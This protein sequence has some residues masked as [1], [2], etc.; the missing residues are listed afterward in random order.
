[1]N[2]KF[3]SYLKFNL[4]NFFHSPFFY[5]I[6]I[7]FSV[8]TSAYFLYRQQFFTGN[9][10][11]DLLSFFSTVPYISIIII[12]ALA[13]KRSDIVF[14]NFV[15]LVYFK[16]ITARFLSVLIIYSIM[17]LSLIPLPV[18]INLFGNVDAGQ[19]VTSII[20]LIF[21]G[22]AVI[23]LCILLSEFFENP[24]LSFVIS[25]LILALFNSCHIFTVYVVLNPFFSSFFKIIS[26]AWHFD[27]AGKGIIDTRD[28]I[29]FISLCGLNLYLTSLVKYKKAGKIFN[30]T[31]KIRN[32]FI[33]IIIILVIL[34]GN[35]WFTRF[36]FSQNK[37]YSISKY[38]KQLLDKAESNIK[39]T[40]YRSGILEKKYPQVRDIS[41]YLIT[42]TSYGNNTSLVIKDPDTDEKAKNL[43]LNYGITSHPLQA[44]SDNSLEYINVYS[45]IV[46]E[47]NGKT[48]LIPFILS[49]QT[50]EFDLDGRIV[51][52]LSDSIRLVNVII[53]NGLGLS[54][55]Y[56]YNFI[57]PWLNSQGF[58]CYPMDVSSPDFAE[59]LDS[60]S[61]PLLV[62]GDSKININAAVAIESYILSGK[63]NG[64]FFVSP[65]SFDFDQWLLLQNQS[66]NIVEMLENWGM[67][68]EDKIAADVSSAVL[69]MESR[70]SEESKEFYS[71]ESLYRENVNYPLFINLLPQTNTSTGATVFWATP[72][73][74]NDE[75]HVKPYLIT[76][77]LSW[78]Y[79]I[80]TTKEKLIET[81]PEYYKTQD[82]TQFEL[83]TQNLGVQ[84]TGPLNGLFTSYSTEKSNLIVIA[85]QYFLNTLTV[86]GM[87]GN[88]YGDYRNFE[89]LTN[90]LLKLNG[91]E[92]L[93]A[94][95]SKSSKDNTLS[96]IT[97]QAVFNK[98][99]SITNV[100]LFVILPLLI[101]LAM[102]LV[103]IL[104]YRR[105]N[106]AKK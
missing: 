43:M 69:T 80:D 32:L 71:Q 85:D 81:I 1:M 6:W 59:Q 91:E 67:R 63:G 40:Y 56:G 74:I 34:N 11:T 101:L 60:S 54:D 52:L 95:Q 66:T 48:E 10:T 24:I 86:Y 35:R 88:G 99:K 13:F 25:S 50:L 12:P 92:E 57:I 100:V 30:K 77:P 33:F 36:D 28:L 27:A 23:S 96:K 84:I 20:C 105:L 37:T 65:Y 94:I 44:L 45:A 39:I 46:I 93:A 103:F 29:W 78:N 14:E 22:A 76:S 18:L 73:T 41:D 9:G 16:R 61:G 82:Y 68:F 7:C 102:T 4:F 38:S 83:S 90:C 104:H 15:P 58:I 31:L 3:N 70:P 42:Y 26:F 97:D 106:Y 8:F 64:L 89:L 21:Y 72:I 62:I 5:I 98:Y 49:A 55:D 47:Y 87:V 53:G 51:H 79:K 17:I 75:A 19:V 2:K